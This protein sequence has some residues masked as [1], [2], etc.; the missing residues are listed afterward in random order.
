MHTV[1]AAEPVPI[2][3]CHRRDVTRILLREARTLAASRHL[4]VS[5]P[6]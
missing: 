5:Y 3:L 4:R 2:S 1:N 6:R